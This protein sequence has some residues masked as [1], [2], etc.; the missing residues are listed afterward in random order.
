MRLTVIK[1]G[2]YSSWARL[3]KKCRCSWNYSGHIFLMEQDI[4]SHLSTYVYCPV[5]MNITI[6]N[7]ICLFCC[8]C[9]WVTV[10]SHT[11]KPHGLKHTRLLCPSPPPRVWSVSYPLSQGCH[12]HPLLTL[13]LPPTI[14]LSIRVFSNESHLLIRWPE[15]WSFSFSP[16]PSNEYSGLIFFRIDWFDFLAAQG[17]LKDSHHSS[18]TSVLRCSDFYIVQLSHPYMTTGKTIAS[19]LQT[20]VGKVIS[21]HFNM[22]SRY[23]IFFPQCA[24][25]F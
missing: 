4:F 19:T 8:Y 13:L 14:F 6:S 18:K 1:L 11:L 24:S 25:F 9:C 3:S 7:S 15:Y 20:F 5:D 21:L 2:R 17:T 23:V 10:M 12:A 22:L 16:S